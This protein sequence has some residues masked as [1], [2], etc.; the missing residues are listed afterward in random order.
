MEEVA[1]IGGPSGVIGSVVDHRSVMAAA[2]ASS[3]L[4]ADSHRVA[5]IAP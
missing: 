1:V 2:E 3:P 5:I 4:R